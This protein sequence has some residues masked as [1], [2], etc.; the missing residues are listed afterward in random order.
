MPDQ[1]CAAALFIS[2]AHTRLAL[3]FLVV[4]FVA[5]VL[6]LPFVPLLPLFRLKQKV[7]ANHPFSLASSFGAA[8][9]LAGLLLLL[10][11]PLQE[12]VFVGSVHP[13]CA[14]V[15]WHTLF[16]YLR[17]EGLQPHQL[18]L[19]HIAYSALAGF[20]GALCVLFH[21]RLAGLSFTA[22]PKWIPGIGLS[23]AYGIHP[24]LIPYY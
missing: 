12:N 7:A 5:T 11:Y 4:G 16:A 18:Y 9:F 15:S 14:T 24:F 19:P 10:L 6:G 13:Q 20:I 2:L 17:H 21:Y 1:E 8:A 23:A 3:S 22:W